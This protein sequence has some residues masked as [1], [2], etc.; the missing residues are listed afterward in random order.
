MFNLGGRTII[1]TLEPSRH[2]FLGVEIPLW[3]FQAVDGISG[4]QLAFHGFRE[5]GHGHS[6]GPAKQRPEK[7]AAVYLHRLYIHMIYDTTLNI[8]ICIYIYIYVNK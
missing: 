6:L 5:G 8:C 2:F 7:G 3:R 4:E 1:P